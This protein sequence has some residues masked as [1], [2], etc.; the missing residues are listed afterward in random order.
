MNYKAYTSF[1]DSQTISQS[2]FEELFC[3]FYSQVAAYAAVILDDKTAGEDI[4]QEVFA[5]VWEKRNILH[6]GDKFRSYL[7]Q[8]TYSRCIDHI[9]KN[10]QSEKYTQESFLKF[11]E[12]YHT[13]LENDCQ[14]I[15]ELFSKD[16]ERS[17]NALLKELPDTRRKVFELAYRDGLKTKEVAENLKMPQ[18]TVE[19]HIYLALKF[20][21][22][23][24]VPSDFFILTL[25]CYFP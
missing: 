11:A 7:F 12:E 14:P 19:S 6:L 22:S 9:K 24:L 2:Q 3:C 15:Q 16:F 21:R 25:L 17:L 8:L 4:A 10:K 23:R 1:S 20:L 5:Y 18:R 13:Y